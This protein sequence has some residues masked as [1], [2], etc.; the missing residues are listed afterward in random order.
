[1]AT[2]IETKTAENWLA[3]GAIRVTQRGEENTYYVT[4]FDHEYFAKNYPCHEC[5][6]A[7]QHQRPILS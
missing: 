6:A 2:E 1:M 7:H 5:G 4:E 3:S